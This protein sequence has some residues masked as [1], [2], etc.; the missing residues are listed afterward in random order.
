MPDRQ[1]V[2]KSTGPIF[3]GNVDDKQEGMWNLV[4]TTEQK[5]FDYLN[6]FLLVQENLG[7]TYNFVDEK[8]VAMLMDSEGVSYIYRI[9]HVF[10][11]PLPQISPTRSN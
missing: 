8:R 4:F 7:A 2:I 6:T 5:A 11:D 3:D 10:V 9:V 1:W